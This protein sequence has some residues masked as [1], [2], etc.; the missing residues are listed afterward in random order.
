MTFE[1]ICRALENESIG[2]VFC[3]QVVEHLH[4]DAVYDMLGTLNRTMKSG[5]P[6]VI[7]T[8]NPLSVFGYHHLFFK[9][10]THVFPVHP[11]T[12]VFMLR[13]SGF[14]DV[15]AQMITPVHG[16]QKL[17]EPKTEDFS[18]AAFEHLKM[19]TGRL[20]QLLYDSLEYYVVGVRK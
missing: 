10:P 1:F 15:Q 19:L 13:Y 2:G 8:L 4:P 18:P 6:L 16:P 14:Q 7:E 11:D 9:D 3:A 20:N 17:P 5:S 12:L